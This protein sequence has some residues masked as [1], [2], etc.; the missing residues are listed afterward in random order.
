MTSN[1]RIKTNLLLAKAFNL[2]DFLDPN[3][4]TH[5]E[6]NYYNELTRLVDKHIDIFVD[7]L[8]TS[9]AQELFY[10][11]EKYTED[12]FN[13]IDDELD[14]II[15]D[16]SLK[17]DEIIEKV[18]NTGLSKGY[19]DIRRRH[20]FNDACKYGLKATQEYNF[21]LIRNVST[22]LRESIK[23][24]IFRG[25]AEG[26]SIHEVARAITDSG[27]QP[28]EGKTLTAYQ[29]ASLIAR[30]EIARSMNTGRLQAYA[31]YG[32]EKVKILTAGDDNV[33]P[34]C[35]EAE[36]KVYTIGEA[37]GLIPFHPCCR[38]S[39]IAHIEH[40]GISRKPLDTLNIISCAPPNPPEQTD[41]F[42]FSATKEFQKLSKKGFIELKNGHRYRIECIEDSSM[43]FRQSKLK[44]EN[45]FQYNVYDEKDNLFVSIYK[46]KKIQ[47]K[48]VEEI[49]KFMDSYPDKLTKNC[50]EIYISFQKYIKDGKEYPGFIEWDNT[51]RI[52]IMNKS[53]D[54]DLEEVLIHELAHSM[55]G[56]FNKYSSSNDY[57]TAFRI[58]LESNAKEFPKEEESWY[59][60]Q[61]AYEDV[62]RKVNGELGRV[63][64][65]DFAETVKLF[66]TN[67][68]WLRG[69][70]PEKEKYLSEIFGI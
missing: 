68:S 29:R 64:S 32:V 50:E 40:E 28:L 9:E 60:S 27:L 24:H 44:K 3:K 18:Y 61:Y 25:V 47:G 30:T 6:L 11:N 21:D 12:F 10:E 15:N 2:E 51:K 1:A 46:S 36:T 38:C 19:N 5:E 58:D 17:A 69:F 48:S 54:Y 22:D 14:T 63:F 53:E 59:V 39:I 49:I 16:S 62:T 34:I 55:D 45:C 23:H 7:W 4:L 43:R 66:I 13:A 35:L 20:V 31:N 52:H 42:T 65:E 41:L 67:R 57:G 33:C 70:F 26:Q 56:G 8:G 37:S